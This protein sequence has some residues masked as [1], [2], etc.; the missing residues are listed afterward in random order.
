MPFSF[1][2]RP[3]PYV[4]RRNDRTLTLGPAAIVSTCSIS[5][6][7]SNCTPKFCP[8][9]FRSA[10]ASNAR[11]QPRRLMIAHAADGG[12]PMLASRLT[13]LPR[14]FFDSFERNDPSAERRPDEQPHVVENLIW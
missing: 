5:P 2:H 10:I 14:I 12:K 1:R 11:L 4:F 13:T 9:I 6:T 7:T 3:R 8:R